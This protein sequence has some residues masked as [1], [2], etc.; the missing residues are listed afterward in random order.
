M[1]NCGEI[2]KIVEF[3]SKIC[4]IVLALVNVF[5][6]FVQR[7]LNKQ[8]IDLNK[9]AI[10]LNKKAIEQTENLSN[11]SHERTELLS[12]KSRFLEYDNLLNGILYEFYVSRN[13]ILGLENNTEKV[14]KEI[15]SKGSSSPLDTQLAILN[16]K[17]FLGKF[18]LSTIFIKLQENGYIFFIKEDIKNT[19]WEG[20]W[21]NNKL[22]NLHKKLGLLVNSIKN[23]DNVVR[24]EVENIEK[25][26]ENWS[27]TEVVLKE[28]SLELIKSSVKKIYSEI[29]NYKGK[30]DSSVEALPE[31][32]DTY[33]IFREL[34]SETMGRRRVD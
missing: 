5:I 24:E 15:D 6:L 2:L 28:D 18:K 22:L 30:F 32:C 25:T 9:K 4:G 13:E 33:N 14:K 1:D 20:V 7:S 3:V 23:L 11:L 29:F 8:S 12:K 34:N 27:H 16:Y 10:D 31:E 26:T 19:I 17:S 21:D